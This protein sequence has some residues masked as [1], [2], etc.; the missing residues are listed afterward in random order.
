MG[1]VRVGP[2]HETLNLSGRD[3]TVA[4]YSAKRIIQHRVAFA[5]QPLWQ[6]RKQYASES[7]YDMHCK[8]RDD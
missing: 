8:Q 7:S 6:T 5:V 4:V 1:L 2:N 3:M